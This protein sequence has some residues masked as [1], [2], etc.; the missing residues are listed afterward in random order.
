MGDSQAASTEVFSSINLEV[1]PCLSQIFGSIE[2]VESEANRLSLD[3]IQEDLEKISGAAKHFVELLREYVE[4]SGQPKANIELRT[5]RHEL[6]TPIGHMVGYS[7]MLQ[8]DVEDQGLSHLAGD[9]D[10]LC[11]NARQLLGL[12]NESFRL[13]VDNLDRN[14][15]TDSDDIELTFEE[16]SLQ[17]Q[18][19]GTV[20]V[21]DDNGSNR[22]LIERLLLRHHH[23]VVTAPNG[24]EAL[25]IL[26][27]SAVDLVLLD[28]MMPEMDG[29]EVLTRLKTH[30]SLRYIPTI[31]ISAH[32]EIEN[33]VTCIER[34]AEDYI[35]KPINPVLLNARVQASLEKKYLRDQEQ[36]YLQ[37]L[38]IE[39]AKS[40]SLLLNI[41][42][43][44]IASR[45]KLNRETIADSF[46]ESSVLF[47]DIIGF[48]NI[49]SDLKPETL[50]SSL[51][52][53]FKAYDALCDQH[54]LEKI[55][56]IGDAYMVAAGL[57]I[58]IENHAQAMCDFALDML[59]TTKTLHP[60][61]IEPFEVRIGISSG[62]V[63]AGVIGRSKFCYDLWGD[64]VNTA[65]RMSS[66][67]KEPHI[68]ISD[69]TFER[70]GC[71][72]DVSDGEIVEIKG[73]GQMKTYV[74][75]GKK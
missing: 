33:V 36:T 62:P 28:Y 53:L 58:P 13:T 40:E 61:L 50:V 37:K 10:R 30:P 63:V 14:S 39:Q 74:L 56:T 65:S 51:N 73:K 55:K 7:E 70:L 1:R 11:K 8:E 59:E 69:A 41:L 17:D 20:L 24:R 18:L 25:S 21:V 57:P 27:R 66:V 35:A 67:G 2:L 68:R 60:K 31:M 38:Q 12:V 47:A 75:Y 52:I 34:G 32:D 3:S 22:D 23:E 64:T 42:P 44:P 49:S 54:G 4:P 45:L 71:A 29:L 16:E 19:R 48:T 5:I 6:R 72:Y 43:A 9:L 15:T 46:A 26:E